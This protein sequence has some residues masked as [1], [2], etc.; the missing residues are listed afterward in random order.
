M[1]RKNSELILKSLEISVAIATLY[2][3]NPPVGIVV[4]PLAIYCL[5]AT[6]K[7]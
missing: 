6:Y 2:T 5:I 3:L 7:D 4:T 1:N